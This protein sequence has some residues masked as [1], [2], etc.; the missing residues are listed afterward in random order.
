MIVC[1]FTLPW[2]DSPQ[3]YSIEFISNL[4]FIFWVELPTKF[5]TAVKQLHLWLCVRVGCRG[6]Y[7]GWKNTEGECLN[8]F[9][10]VECMEFCFPNPFVSLFLSLL[11]APLDFLE[12]RGINVAFELCKSF[13]N[14][15][16]V[17]VCAAL[18]E[19]R[20]SGKVLDD[21]PVFISRDS[22]LLVFTALKGNYSTGAARLLL[23]FRI[24]NLYIVKFDF[25]VYQ[26]VTSESKIWVLWVGVCQLQQVEISLRHWKISVYLHGFLVHIIM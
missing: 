15:V 8:L 10:L 19:G 4:R 21:C 23:R 6:E 16:C 1:S 22:Q 20:V 18:W 14:S 26:A 2:L 9:V 12:E 17:C 11:G 5:L 25:W 3:L 7:W 24:S 13:K